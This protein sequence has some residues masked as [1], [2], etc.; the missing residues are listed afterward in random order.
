MA[1]ATTYTNK[2]HGQ[3]IVVV[4]GTSGI[5]F[6]VAE[7]AIELGA[8]VIVASSNPTRVSE[9]VSRIETTYPSAKG[10]ISGIPLD[11]GNIST[12]DANVK[13][14]FEKITE[15][16]QTLN[17]V[18]FTAGDDLRPGNLDTL[19]AEDLIKSSTVRY[20]GAIFVVKYAKKVLP[21]STGSSITITT[22]SISEKPSPG[23][24][25]GNGTATGIHGLAR[26]FA[27]DLAPV[28]V[29]AISPGIVDTELLRKFPKHLVDVYAKKTATGQIAAVEDVAEAYLYVIKDKNVTGSVIS[30]NGGGLLT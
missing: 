27:L 19:V 24:G 16:G 5:G 29:N 1:D 7:G 30:T 9:A 14:F 18:V 10:R 13:A 4:G 25:V 8:T 23:F 20:Y 2:L 11:L 21:K 15:G 22:G 6:A 26:G 28:R 17:H 3:R 12:L